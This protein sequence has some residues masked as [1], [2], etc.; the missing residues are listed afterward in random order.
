MHRE[1]NDR[2]LPKPADLDRRIFIRLTNNRH[3]VT[4]ATSPD[5]RTWTRYPNSMEV[6]GYHHNVAYGFLSLRPALY[7]AGPGEV[8]FRNFTYRALP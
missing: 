1:G 3:I 8:K 7:A 2:I 5:G 4:L 6:S